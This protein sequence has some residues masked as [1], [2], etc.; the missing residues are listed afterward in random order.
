[1]LLLLQGVKYVDI[2]MR[3]LTY[4]TVL[5]TVEQDANLNC[6]RWHSIT[7]PSFFCH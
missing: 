7:E 1:L 2:K 3:I 5:I 6:R 4:V